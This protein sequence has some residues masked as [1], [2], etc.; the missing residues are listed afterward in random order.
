[1]GAT[2]VSYFIQFQS[3][4]CVIAVLFNFFIFLVNHE[5]FYD[6]F[7]SIFSAAPQ[8]SGDSDIETAFQRRFHI[9]VDES[10]QNNVS[11]FTRR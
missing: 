11:F 7:K 5:S 6:A 2:N 4:K 9:S 3:Q 8:A 1:M 10:E